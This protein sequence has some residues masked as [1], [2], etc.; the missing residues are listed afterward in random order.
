M[1]S[2]LASHPADPGLIPGVPE[3]FSKKNCLGEKIVNVDTLF[4][5]AAA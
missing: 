2:V 4:D 5:T 3:V 1:D